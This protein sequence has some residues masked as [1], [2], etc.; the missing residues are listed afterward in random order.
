[1]RDLAFDGESDDETSSFDS[2][3]FGWNSDLNVKSDADSVVKCASIGT[4]EHLTPNNC[5]FTLLSPFQKWQL[6]CFHSN[7]MFLTVCNS[8]F[9]N[10][11]T[12]K[13]WR[14]SVGKYES[15]E[16]FSKTVHF[17]SVFCEMDVVQQCTEAQAGMVQ[18]GLSRC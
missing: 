2:P 3:H 11:H 17:L 10:L 8:L 6:V 12:H 18:D 7:T 13:I 16:T 14:R 9:S 5:L 15:Y 4:G 1:M